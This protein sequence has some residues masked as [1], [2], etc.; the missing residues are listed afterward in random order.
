[1]ADIS[2]SPHHTNTH[3]YKHQSCICHVTYIQHTLT[4]SAYFTRPRVRQ[5]WARSKLF[6]KTILIMAKRVG[7]SSNNTTFGKNILHFISRYHILHISSNTIFATFI[8]VPNP[9][10]IN[11]SWRRLLSRN[12]LRVTQYIQLQSL[13]PIAH[14]CSLTLTFHSNTDIAT[15]SPPLFTHS[16]P[17]MY[18]FIRL[19]STCCLPTPLT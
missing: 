5:Q 17:V 4:N 10:T 16:H 3:V 14:S 12:A 7:M 18:Y 19:W 13:H 1:M 2:Q 9:K 15:P 8:A 11:P 6:P